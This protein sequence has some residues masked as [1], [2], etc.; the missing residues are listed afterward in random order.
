MRLGERCC[1]GI[2]TLHYEREMRAKEKHSGALSIAVTAGRYGSCNQLPSH[3]H[4][5]GM[6]RS[7]GRL[8]P[9]DILRRGLRRAEATTA[10]V[11]SGPT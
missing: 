8:A 4:P 10:S 3:R 11:E 6:L 1:S 7:A 2:T 9:R 5:L